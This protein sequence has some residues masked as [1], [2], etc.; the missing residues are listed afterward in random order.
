MEYKDFLKA[1]SPIIPFN[2]D[3]EVFYSAVKQFY[4]KYG[5]QSIEVYNENPYLL[6]IEFDLPFRYFRKQEGLGIMRYSKINVPSF[7]MHKKEVYA[8]ITD[9]LRQNE[10]NGNSYIYLHS[11]YMKLRKCFPH[12]SEKRIRAYLNCYSDVFFIDEDERV[13]FRITKYNESFIYKKMKPLIEGG[14]CATSDFEYEDNADLC[15][16]QNNAIRQLMTNN[17]SILTGGPGTG[18]TTT[19]KS[20]FETYRNQ[21]PERRIQ[22][23]APTG[24]AARRLTEAIGDSDYKA[25]TLHSIVFR[26]QFSKDVEDIDL[27]I[28]D[29]A[30]MIP[31]DIFAEFLKHIN[32]TQVVL[33]GDEDQLPAIGA[34]N[35]LH[36]LISLNVN[37]AKLTENHRNKDVIIK[38]AIKVKDKDINLE[39]NDTNFSFIEASS[40]EM[41]EVAASLWRTNDTVILTPYRNETYH[42][43]KLIHKKLFPN[44]E[45]EGRLPYEVGDR[46]MFLHNRRRKGYVNGD[47]GTIIGI[48]NDQYI[49]TLNNDSCDEVS[50]PIDNTE[51]M[52]Y[53]Y[54]I[55][56]H[57]SQGSEYKTVII[58]IPKD[59][60]NIFS[61]KLL[62]TAIT[63]AREKVIFVGDR[64]ELT[65]LILSANEDERDTLLELY[66]PVEREE[67]KPSLNYEEKE[68]VMVDNTDKEDKK[69]IS[70]DTEKKDR[71]IYKSKIEEMEERMKKR[72]IA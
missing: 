59:C 5:D 61:R 40:Y 45:E 24:K 55:T 17:T 49:I 16:E 44:S 71:D 19:V 20:L 25:V 2:K 6:T 37:T 3:D 43:N 36:D 18:K 31:I 34:G 13:A 69:D 28:I 67:D 12:T 27:C 50:I 54:A 53:A 29:E 32:P 41:D 23:A 58:E 42:V 68:Y 8:C 72:S 60:S 70:E 10:T 39:F 64:D 7:E 46:V 26:E 35:L 65:K 15:D 51:D 66:K 11:L 4:T 1:L 21:Y 33:L 30:S 52:T 62:Y 56:V 63:R 9:L 14:Y 57:K 22:L 48:E 38:N 47:T